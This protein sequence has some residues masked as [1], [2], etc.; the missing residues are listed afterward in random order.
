MAVALGTFVSAVKEKI[1][2]EEL[3]RKTIAIDAFNTI[4]QFLSIIRQ[5]D[6]TPLVDAKGRVTS[7]L[8]GLL[9]RTINLVE[10]DITPIFVFDGIPPVLKKRTLEARM[11]AR[12]T[13]LEGW[14]TAKKKGLIEEARTY[15]MKSTRINEEIINSSK[16]LLNYM[17]IPFI[18][19]PSEGEAQA[20]YLS[21]EGVVYAS[22][23]QDYDSFLYGADT[24]IRNIT[25]TGRRKLP[26]KNVFVEVSIER[27][28][29]KDLLTSMGISLEKLIWLSIL[30]GNDYDTGIAGIGPKTAL[31]IVKGHDSLSGVMQFVKE[32]YKAEIDA[33]PSDVEGLFKRPD[34]LHLS[35]SDIEM[36][37]KNAK[38]DKGRLLKFMC[39]EHGFT[40]ERVEKAAEKLVTKSESANQKGIN[41][42][43]Q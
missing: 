39:D 30:I 4:Y 26:K 35:A 23:S 2:L 20:A 12:K 37:K 13:A 7:H 9:Y 1:G 14:E 27:T 18:Q 40:T 19:A 5:P 6:G 34:V 22:A 28:Q 41:S 25:V 24:V 29:L 31:K 3:E 21:K 15:A 8:S 36:L 11:N 32:K 16:E 17:G 33:N 10:H 42:W 38:A 43:M